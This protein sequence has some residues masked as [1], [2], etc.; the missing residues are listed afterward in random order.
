MSSSFRQGQGKDHGFRQ[1]G[2]S[3]APFPHH[4]DHRLDARLLI[5]R[6]QLGTGL[7]FLV[8]F[9]V[10][11]IWGRFPVPYRDDWD[12]LNFHLT[13]SVT[14]S[15]LFVPHNEHMIPLP[16]LIFAAQCDL[17]AF[18]R[19]SVAAPPPDP[20]K[21]ASARLPVATRRADGPPI[22]VDG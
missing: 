7:L 5:A 9:V 22:R 14:F 21:P 1:A 12:W 8:S 15:S 20:G 4:P 18:H 6:I 17:A 2:S 10:F 11:A 13:S 3:R 16:R 19:A